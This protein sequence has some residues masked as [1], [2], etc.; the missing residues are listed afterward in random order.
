MADEVAAF[1]DA[2]LVSGAVIAGIGDVDGVGIDGLRL[3]VINDLRKKRDRRGKRLREI[4]ART[5]QAGVSFTEGPGR[6][7]VR[8]EH[9]IGVAD[10]PAVDA[11]RAIVAIVGPD[12]VSVEPGEIAL[13]LVVPPLSEEEN[14][15]DDIGAGVGAEAALRQTNGGDE[16]G[17][18]GDVFTRRAIGLVHG[19]RTGDERRESAGLQQVDRARDEIVVEPKPHRPIGAV[20]AH[21]SIRERRIA[22]GEI[23]ARRQIGAREVG[24][25]DAGPRLQQASDAGSHGIDLDAGDMH[26]VAQ[27]GRD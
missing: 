20:R 14:V 9:E 27:V 5:R 23:E 22:D 3:A 13:S 19:A 12:L 6:R 2:A 18:L 8:A 17:R 21:G 24:V 7:G 4:H 11:D 10:E 15:D 25:E 16:I 1:T 26:L